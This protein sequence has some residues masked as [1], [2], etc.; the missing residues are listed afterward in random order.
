MSAVIFLAMG[1]V[2]IWLLAKGR[3]TGEIMARGWGASVRIYRR[4]SDTV[5]YW[6]TFW[7][8]LILALLCTIVG[9][10]MAFKTMAN[11]VA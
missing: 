7:M 11:H 5:M 10:V 9:I 2:F 3:S 1:A 8:Y 6:I 4:D